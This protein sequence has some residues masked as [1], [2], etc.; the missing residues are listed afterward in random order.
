MMTDWSAD[1]GTRNYRIPQ[2]TDARNVWDLLACVLCFLMIAS[3]LLGYLW[4]RSHIVS[5]GYSLQQSKQLEEALV[6]VQNSLI[7]EE[8]TLKS[9]ER[10]DFMA[11]N[12][13]AMEPLG[14]YQ[15]VVLRFHEIGVDPPG[16]TILANIGRTD[17]QLRKPAAHN[18][19]N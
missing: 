7:A 8:E 15:R 5:L 14:P 10:I 18:S 1:V 11:R 12:D 16:G 2:G 13:L 4:I 9:P 6:R 17:I 19:N 3:S